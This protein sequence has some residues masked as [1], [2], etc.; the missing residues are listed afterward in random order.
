MAWVALP[1]DRLRVDCRPVVAPTVVTPAMIMVIALIR[2]VDQVL[3]AVIEIPGMPTFVVPGPRGAMH[4]AE[5]R[6]ER[7]TMIRSDGTGLRAV[8]H[9][10]TFNPPNG[11]LRTGQH[12]LIGILESKQVRED[13][14]GTENRLKTEADFCPRWNREDVARHP[15]VIRAVIALAIGQNT[16]GARA[17]TLW[18][19]IGPRDRVGLITFG[20]IR[21]GELTTVRRIDADDPQLQ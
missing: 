10:G 20:V 11:D 2:S 14:V 5:R 1:G 3:H 9:A 21:H 15:H 4:R 19:V 16:I 6:D 18:A 7:A 8:H 13:V 12:L 17:P